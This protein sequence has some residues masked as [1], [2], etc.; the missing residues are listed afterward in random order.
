MMI[1]A[2]FALLLGG[3][4]GL[5]QEKNS[6]AG[7]QSGLPKALSTADVKESEKPKNLFTR[8]E[9]ESGSLAV[10]RDP[11]VPPVKALPQEPP[12]KMHLA[13]I[14]W[15]KNQPTAIINGVL[16]TIGGS[17]DGKIVKVIDK[18]RV[19]LEENGQETELFIGR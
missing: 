1:L 10:L 4:D 17:V 9:E 5:D 13:G 19:I 15:D 8:L 7:H 3:C 14:L 18:D 2:A 12:K 11:F 16:V 6:G